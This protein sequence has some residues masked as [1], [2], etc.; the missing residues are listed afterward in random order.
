MRGFILAAGKGTRLAPRTDSVPKILVPVLGIPLLDRLRHWLHQHGVTQLALNTHH[1]AAVLQA[2]LEKPDRHLPRPQI[3]HEPRLLGTGGALV[4][5]GSFWRGD[6]LLVWNGDI[7]CDLDPRRLMEAH[8][9]PRAGDERPALAT[10]A[11]QA[12]EGNS[13]LLVD[14][15]GN[16]CGL[17]SPRRNLYRMVATPQGEVRKMGFTGISVLAPALLGMLPAGGAF[18]ILEALLD[19]MED[20]AVARALDVGTAF[21]GTIGTPGQLE[22]LETGLKARPELLAGWSPGD[23]QP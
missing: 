2:H 10:L 4:N 13:H 18:D 21:Y 17:D 5:A 15:S 22:A 8:A 11:V 9:A 6:P 7:L 3:F 23:S 16:L 1:L 12:R 19:L 20:G 14:A